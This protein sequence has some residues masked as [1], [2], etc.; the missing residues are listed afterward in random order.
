MDKGW[1]SCRVK[2]INISPEISPKS[3]VILSLR[4]GEALS[5]AKGL[6]IQI[7][8]RCF[9]ALNIINSGFLDG[10]NIWVMSLIYA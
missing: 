2:P 9:V 5:A 10:P 7:Y 8:Y 6:F 3:R 1:F 4:S